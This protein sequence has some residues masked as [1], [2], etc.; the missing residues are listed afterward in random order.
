MGL[1]AFRL[2][3]LHDGTSADFGKSESCIF[4][5]SHSRAKFSGDN[6]SKPSKFRIIIIIYNHNPLSSVMTGG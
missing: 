4:E 6:V 1:G 3:A 5:R 2:D